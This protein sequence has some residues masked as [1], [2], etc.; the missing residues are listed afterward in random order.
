MNEHEIYASA[1]WCNDTSADLDIYCR[2]GEHLASVNSQDSPGEI[3]LSQQV[4]LAAAHQ[5]A[6][7]AA[8]EQP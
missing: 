7:A 4:Y 3:T 2:C 6:I 8:G 5:R 1:S